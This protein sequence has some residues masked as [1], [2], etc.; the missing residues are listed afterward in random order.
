MRAFYCRGANCR[1]CLP[2]KCVGANRLRRRW[3]RYAIIQRMLGRVSPGD[4]RLSCRSVPGRDAACN[5]P[6]RTGRPSIRRSILRTSVGSNVSRTKRAG[7]RMPAAL[8]GG[9]AGC[10][11]KARRCWPASQG[12]GAVATRCGWSIHP[13][14]AT[15]VRRWQPPMGQHHGCTWMAP[16]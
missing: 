8:P 12:V 11:A 16:V 9:H 4:V 3:A 2:G 14:C 15:P 6:W 5:D 10:P 1:A 7:Q 13:G